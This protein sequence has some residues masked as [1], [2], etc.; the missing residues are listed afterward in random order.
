[1]LAFLFVSLKVGAKLDTS[2]R[3]KFSTFGLQQVQP[4]STKLMA[5]QDLIFIGRC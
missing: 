1:M 5:A 4:L 3:E 2:D